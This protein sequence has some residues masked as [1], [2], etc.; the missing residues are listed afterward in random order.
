LS[1]F[2]SP[3]QLWDV[4]PAHVV[5]RSSPGRS[6][7]LKDLDFAYDLAPL[8]PVIP[9]TLVYV[10]P[11]DAKSL[12]D[13]AP[14]LRSLGLATTLIKEICHLYG[15]FLKSHRYFVEKEYTNIA[16]H[17]LSSMQHCPDLS[18]DLQ[19]NI[20]L[21]FQGTRIKYEPTCQQAKAVVLQN[22]FA[23]L[24]SPVS[25]Q[26]SPS[27]QP[28]SSFSKVR[29]LLPLL[30]ILL[31]SITDSFFFPFVH[32]YSLIAIHYRPPPNLRPKLLPQFCR[33]A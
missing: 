22:V 3:I 9:S 6:S 13:I 5:L 27:W 21:F 18:G 16:Q 10:L 1:H 29:S 12:P 17:L 32:S 31:P 25:C 26:S 7:R 33:T 4:S 28:K 30:L 14:E 2:P 20:D 11:F 8:P 15:Q 23:R 19:S 24:D